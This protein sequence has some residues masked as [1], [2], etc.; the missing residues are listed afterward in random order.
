MPAT[1]LDK[2]SADTAFFGHPK[3][4]FVCFMTEMWERFSY[5]GMRALLIF[6]LTQH[7]L[8]SDEKAYL[9]YGDY[10]ALVYVT[11]VIGGVL[12][13]RYLGSRKAVNFADLLFVFGHL[14]LAIQGLI[15][16]AAPT[17]IPGAPTT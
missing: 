4:L 5:Y 6:Y 11:P 17:A 9:I 7:F 3:G 13:D 10:S 2:A 15:A 16:V 1:P 12:S 14:R 8:F